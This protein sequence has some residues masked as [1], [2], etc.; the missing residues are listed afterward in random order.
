MGEV[1]CSTPE[2]ALAGLAEGARCDPS[3]EDPADA[4]AHN[5]ISLTSETSP[6]L[7]VL[8]LRVLSRDR[9]KKQMNKI[10]NKQTTREEY[11]PPNPLEWLSWIITS[12]AGLNLLGALVF[13]SKEAFGTYLKLK[14]W[15]VKALAGT[16]VSSAY[17]RL[18][19]FCSQPLLLAWRWAGTAWG[20]RSREAVVFAGILYLPLRHL[21]IHVHFYLYS[22]FIKA[23]GHAI[24]W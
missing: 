19:C 21:V 3:T 24:G 13:E 18:L 2:P 8:P 10:R 20:G 14:W 6:G 15:A 1:P 11:K 17:A 5:S 22:G 9:N 4:T 23:M 12:R 16:G 7:S